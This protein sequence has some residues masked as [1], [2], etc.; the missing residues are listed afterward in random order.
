[1]SKTHLLLLCFTH[2]YYVII[3]Y[4]VL[5]ERLKMNNQLL[6]LRKEYREQIE[7]KD[8]ISKVLSST[9]IIIFLFFIMGLVI[10]S[11]SNLHYIR[12]ILF[13]LIISFIIVAIYHS[14]I[15]NDKNKLIMYV[16]IITKYEDCS[17]GKWKDVRKDFL[18]L[19]IQFMNDLDIIGKS[20]LFQL[21][22]FTSSLGGKR[23]LLDTLSLRN[24]SKKSIL[25]N[26]EA[27][28]ELKDNFGF[29]LQFQEKLSN[30]EKIEKID[31]E[32]F[33]YLFD[34]K[35]NNKLKDLIISTIISILTIITF[36]LSMFNLIS[37]YYFIGLF[38]FQIASSYF[39]TIIY[40]NEF[41]T[42]SICAR[43][44]SMLKNVYNYIKRQKF[45][46]EKNKMLQNDII[47]GQKTLDKLIKISILDSFRC[48]FITYI[49][50]NVFLSLN[51]VILY[52]YARLLNN[53]NQIFK[54]SIKA[55]EELE[56]LVSLSTICFIKKD[57]CKPVFNDTISIKVSNIKHPLLEEEKCIA[58][59]FECNSDIN[60]ITGSNMSGKTS[61]MR[62]I[63]INLVLAYTG[64][65]VNASSFSCS[66]MKIF[67]SINVKDDINNGI[68]TFYGELQ[69]IKTIL[70]FSNK[71]KEPMIIFIDEIFKGTNYNDRIFGAM[72]TLKKL[73]LLNC[74]VFMTT[75]DFELC[76]IN[77]KKIKNYHFSEL[78][79]NNRIF[80]DYKI[81]DGK[82]TTTNAKYLMKQMQIIN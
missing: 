35:T 7:K 6:E 17:N 51:F 73:S 12:V 40:K 4:V 81:K 74:I 33:F 36:V 56:T 22:D 46:S 64:A 5:K 21:I 67:T 72:E 48:N 75:H 53:E 68:S 34:K 2:F 57:V 70:D 41:N 39:Y 77:N 66:I 24:V 58:N 37:S 10:Y 61:F 27:I 60:I 45:S 14:V 26:Q 65:Y 30:I 78:Y 62:T 3:L 38:F 29:V 18:D 28:T 15:K 82:C 71:N 11:N 23:R 9:R 42:I 19:D 8:K 80:F 43:K 20:S 1:M 32:E 76:E 52:N 50:F 69:R 49:V 79:N 63:G 25:S 13:F 54:K 59:D 44:F 16:D 47:E 55:L 31:F